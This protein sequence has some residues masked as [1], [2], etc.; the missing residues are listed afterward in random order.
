[1]IRRAAAT[2]VDGPADRLNIGAV[3]VRRGQRERLR[4]GA[5]VTTANATKLL[6]TPN[7]AA[8][9]LAVSRTKIY[10]LMASG[11]LRSIHI[12]RLRRVPIDALRDFIEAMESVMS[13]RGRRGH[14]EGSVFQR[15]NGMWVAQVDL[16]WIGGRRRRRT[17]YGGS[18]REVIAKRDQLRSQL[19]KG[20][21]LAD[22]PRT[23]EQWLNEWLRTVKAGDGTSQSTLDRYDQIVRVHLIPLVG[24]IKLSAL[25]PRDVQLMVSHLRESAAP[26]SVVKIH[27]VL[28]NAL[29][30][31]ERMDLVHRNVAK[32][33]RSATLTRTERRA[34]TPSEALALLSQLQGDRLEGLFILALSTGLRRGEVLGLR[35]QDID[36]PGRAL[37]VR[38]AVQR[39][40]GELRFVP[41]KT[42][43]STRSMPLSELTV[44]ALTAQRARQAEDR[45]LVGAAWEDHGLVFATHLGT[46]LEP[47]NVNRRFSAA[48][49]AAGL[50]WV[51][52]H[53]LR[54][55][56]PA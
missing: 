10:E 20:V 18:E 32:A 1:V 28:R 55:V 49:S 30:D 40:N 9:Q 5:K 27:G 2:F 11:T 17:V 37:F 43:R 25:A 6:L 56:V 4:T 33:V 23:V 26:A 3:R 46:P 34:L 36:L 16:G 7:E 38:Q 31:A 45:L 35:W 47:R 42:H 29:A 24:R 12:G 22:P 21:N 44:S 15:A 19:G 52:L 51:R 14:G 50:E 8:E 48:R 41:P 13:G 39:I 54:H 53:D